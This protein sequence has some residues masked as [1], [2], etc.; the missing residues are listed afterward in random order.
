MTSRKSAIFR[1]M[2]MNAR[3]PSGR[4]NASVVDLLP[5]LRRIAEARVRD[6]DTVEDVVQETVKRVIEVQDRLAPGALSS[7]AVVTLRNLMLS[8]ERQS[9]VHA[10][11]AH[12]LIE[13]RE[14]ER[15]DEVAMKEEERQAV[16]AALTRLP[17]RDREALI[18][19]EVTG[20]STAALARQFG[21]TPGAV[22]VRLART[23]ARVRLEYVLSLRGIELPTARCRPVLLALSSGDKRRQ[24]ATDA[25]NHLLHCPTCASLSQPLL[26]RRR[27]LA[28]LVP[29]QLM[30]KRLSGYLRAHQTQALT[31]GGAGAIT[32]A[33]AITVM[34]S[35]RPQTAGGPFLV[36]NQRARARAVATI[37][38][39]AGDG[40]SARGVRVLSVPSD[41][42]FW[43]G[44]GQRDR[45]WVRLKT[46][47]ESSIRVE[48]GK[49]V[50]FSGRV[51]SHRDGF[52]D[53]MNVQP[54]EGR[55]VLQDQDQ[56]IEVLEKD[57]RVK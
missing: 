32:A 49:R 6:P 35:N 40:V 17:F 33:V 51:V 53:R 30:V 19:H 1:M 24:V 26:R 42:G 15:P 20:T 41:E 10:R 43:I 39:Y 2:P 27:A 52:A 29:L 34:L 48:R 8:L 5:L 16:A 31:V 44:T 50:S 7:Y 55:A 54:R 56:H 36:A 22:A 13:P 12:R 38:R 4:Q 46:S 25:S 45:V 47:G 28:A 21:S 14:P 37:D 23:R 3:A 18:A 9:E 57:M 11:H